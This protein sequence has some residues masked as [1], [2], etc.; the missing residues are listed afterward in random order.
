MYV[1]QR[2]KTLCL[3]FVIAEKKCNLL[4]DRE[5]KC[6]YKVLKNGVTPAIQ[7]HVRFIYALLAALGRTKVAI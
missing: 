4:Q 7:F 1:L 2:N 6:I 5:K 3:P